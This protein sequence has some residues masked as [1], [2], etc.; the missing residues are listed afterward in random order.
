MAYMNQERKKEL[1]P[2]IKAVAKKYGMKISI[3]VRHHSTLVINVSR[4]PIDFGEYTHGDGYIQVNH[5]HIEKHYE[6]DAR[7][8]LTELTAAAHEGNWD[9]SDTMTDYFNVGWYVDINIGRWNKP[10]EYNGP[11]APARSDAFGFP[12][13]IVEEIE[14]T[15]PAEVA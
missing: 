15:L 14:L 12:M 10:Y 11:K 6:G 4:G 1:A 3:A 9:K 8:F 5:Y 13:D 2:A 7:D